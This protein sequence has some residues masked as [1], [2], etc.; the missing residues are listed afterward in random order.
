M[1]EVT[2]GVRVPL[3]RNSTEAYYETTALNALCVNGDSGN[4]T[5][6]NL[7]AGSDALW[8]SEYDTDMA[9]VGVDGGSGLRSLS[10][11]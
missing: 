8:P 11:A 9:A 1:L 5:F 4:S 10:V 2:Y 6:F 3:W 7:E